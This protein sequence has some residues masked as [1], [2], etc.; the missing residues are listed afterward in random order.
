MEWRTVGYSG[1]AIIPVLCE[2]QPLTL[3]DLNYL[4]RDRE[5]ILYREVDG[6]PLISEPKIYREKMAVVTNK[7]AR[8]EIVDNVIMIPN[9]TTGSYN[10]SFAS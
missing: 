10:L 8:F 7:E 9:I 6:D 3:E 2:V 4:S 1:P 5:L